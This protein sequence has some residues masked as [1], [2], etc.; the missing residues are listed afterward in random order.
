MYS[1]GAVIGGV[2]LGPACA[3]CVTR[4]PLINWMDVLIDW[5]GLDGRHCRRT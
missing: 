5:I 1:M 3:E 2:G 4:Q